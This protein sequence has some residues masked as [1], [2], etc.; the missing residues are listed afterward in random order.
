MASEEYWKKNHLERN[1]EVDAM[2]QNATRNF[3]RGAGPRF[4]T[5]GR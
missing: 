1:A 4:R 2:I 5:L 3:A